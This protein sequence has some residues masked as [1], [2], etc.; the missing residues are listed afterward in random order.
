MKN[1]ALLR[2][3]I[4]KMCADQYHLLTGTLV[5]AME[6]AGIHPLQTRELTGSQAAQ[7]AAAFD[8]AIFPLL[9]PLAVDPDGPPPIMI[10][11]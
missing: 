11:S 9:T 1:L 3:R 2:Q 4:L 5:P 8:D 6:K 7:V 10:A